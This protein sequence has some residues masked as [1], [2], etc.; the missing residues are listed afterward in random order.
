MCVVV[1]SASSLNYVQVIT[2]DEQRFG[3]VTIK[4]HNTVY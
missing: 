1:I 3:H 4:G 2:H